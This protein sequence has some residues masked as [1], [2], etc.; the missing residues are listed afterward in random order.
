[1]VGCD[2]L[3]VCNMVRCHALC[4]C[5]CMLLRPPRTRGA[6]VRL[7]SPQKIMHIDGANPLDDEKH[8]NLRNAGPYAI[9]T[10][11][12]SLFTHYY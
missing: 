9:T 10:N 12:Y 5:W 8:M 7:N 4:M 1:M 3:W 2:E 6:L 11:Y